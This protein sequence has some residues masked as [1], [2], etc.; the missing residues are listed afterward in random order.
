MICD[1]TR[2]P[3]RVPKKGE[4][5]KWVW[6]EMGHPRECV[7]LE[8]IPRVGRQQSHVSLYFHDPC[9]PENI[10]PRLEMSPG[11]RSHQADP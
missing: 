5:R 6:M 11:G 8:G 7:D 9:Y 10:W 4:K 1:S 3:E 2:C